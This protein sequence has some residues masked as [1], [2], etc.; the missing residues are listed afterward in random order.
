MEATAIN[1]AAST[2]R[3]QNTDDTYVLLST[4]WK[5][6]EKKGFE[7]FLDRSLTYFLNIHKYITGNRVMSIE[8]QQ[9]ADVYSLENKPR[10]REG[11]SNLKISRST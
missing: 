11:E 1:G 3:Y 9:L 7:M 8:K 5:L 10:K 4:E 2:E 6:R